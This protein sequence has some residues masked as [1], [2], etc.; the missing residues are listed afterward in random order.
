[1][2]PRCLETSPFDGS[3]VIW[4]KWLK[5]LD[6]KGQRADEP[7][8]LAVERGAPFTVWIPVD[9]T[10]GQ[11]P[12]SSIQRKDLSASEDAELMVRLTARAV[13]LGS[14]VADARWFDL[15][16]ARGDFELGRFVPLKADPERDVWQW[17]GWEDFGSIPTESESDLPATRP[18]S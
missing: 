3:R 9:A 7:S 15:D 11:L 14:E 5:V 6:E 4:K 13:G 18:A 10:V 2:H 1:M 12:L 17:E 8:W 16:T